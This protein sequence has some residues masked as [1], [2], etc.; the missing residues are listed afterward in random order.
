MSNNLKC[1]ICEIN[2]KTNETE[3]GTLI[4]EQCEIDHC[5]VYYCSDSGESWLIW[6]D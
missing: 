5:K 1:D 2:D 4:C 3:C 6:E